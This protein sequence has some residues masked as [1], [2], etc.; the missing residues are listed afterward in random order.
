VRRLPLWGWLAQF[1]PWLCYL[2]LH[3]P[4]LPC[5]CLFLASYSPPSRRI[6]VHTPRR[7]EARRALQSFTCW[8]FT[9]ALR[10][11]FSPRGIFFPLAS[12][13]LYLTAAPSCIVAPTG[14]CPQAG[15]TTTVPLF[16]LSLARATG[17]FDHGVPVRPFL[18]PTPPSH[19]K[20]LR[21]PSGFP[22]ASHSAALAAEALRQRFR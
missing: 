1:P 17:S 6:I 2:R 5:L 14:C 11:P 13:W 20:E 19:R 8:A 7:P 15:L 22:I 9:A 3:Q 10:L 12:S 16:G 21:S 4:T 18:F